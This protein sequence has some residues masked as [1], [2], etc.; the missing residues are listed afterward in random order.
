MPKK[1]PGSVCSTFPAHIGVPFIT[2]DNSNFSLTQTF[3]SYEINR[4]R[5]IRAKTQTIQSFDCHEIDCLSDDCF[6]FPG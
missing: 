5:I 4:Y 1:K 2:I 6:T 3:Q